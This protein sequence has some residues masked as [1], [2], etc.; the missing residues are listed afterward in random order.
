MY[1]LYSQALSSAEALAR[2][3]KHIKRA[4]DNAKRGLFPLSVVPPPPPPPRGLIFPLPSLP[5]TQT[6][7]QATT[8]AKLRKRHLKTVFALL[9]SLSRLFHLV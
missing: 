5:T 1:I 6:E 2:I 3:L 9:Q 8:T 4:V 7:S